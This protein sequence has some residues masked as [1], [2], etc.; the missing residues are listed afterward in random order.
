MT[1]E[2]ASEDVDDETTA[3]T[4]ESSAAAATAV[5]VTTGARLHLGPLNWPGPQAGDRPDFGGLGMMIEQ[6]ATRVLARPAAAWDALVCER[7]KLLAALDN[8][9]PRDVTLQATAPPHAGLGSG[10]QREL[11]IAAACGVPR[12]PEALA[13]AT[14]RGRRSAIGLHGFCRGGVLRDG[15]RPQG[16][17]I[18]QLVRR[19]PAPNWP[20]L[21]VRLPE[22]SSEGLS[23][24]A[25]RAAFAQLPAMSPDI[26]GR[27]KDLATEALDTLADPVGFARA[28]TEFGQLVGR[29]F[30]PVQGGVMADD[31]WLALLEPLQAAGCGAVQS[32]WG[33]TVAVLGD[34]DRALP[35]LPEGSDIERVT[36]RDAPAEIMTARGTSGFEESLRALT[37][38]L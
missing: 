20:L 17:A 8:D 26:R 3:A 37:D 2:H 27:L 28:A 19:E 30:A 13:A 11:A 1:A 12:E 29:F 24:A 7:P 15:G 38:P 5:Q 21:L 31:R 6:P 18:G 35:L 36:I 9:P 25:E 16:E 14:G 22:R 10:T 23:G 4:A 32:S 34:V 33:P